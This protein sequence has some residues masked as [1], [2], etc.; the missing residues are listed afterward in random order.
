MRRP[1]RVFYAEYL[2]TSSVTSLHSHHLYLPIQLSLKAL[3]FEMSELDAE[4]H[5]QHSN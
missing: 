3:G 4:F 1:L 2:P 5:K